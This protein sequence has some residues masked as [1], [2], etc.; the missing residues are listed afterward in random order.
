VSSTVLLES[1]GAIMRLGLRSVLADAHCRVLEED[2]ATR[3]DAVLID[4]DQPAYDAA[5]R[6][7]QAQHPSAS[8]IAC[9]T[10]HPVM[11][12]FETDQADAERPLTALALI[13]AVG[14]DV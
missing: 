6:C 2:C 13:V 4:M 10:C 12:I 9:S 5:A 1:F 3:I 8:V 7:L 11:R 14:V